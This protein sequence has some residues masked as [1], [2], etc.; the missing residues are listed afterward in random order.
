[1][2]AIG[3]S[4]FLGRASRPARRNLSMSMLE[5]SGGV[6]EEKSALS[7]FAG[8]GRSLSSS[9][10]TSAAPLRSA[11]TAAS[12]SA[13]PAEVELPTNDNDPSLLRIRHTSAHVM[14][15][16]VQ[17]VFPEAQVTIGPW[18]DNG[19]YYDFY[20]PDTVDEEGN[21]VPGRKLVDG[22]LKKIKKA[23]DKIIK[24]KLPIHRE[25]VS[26]EEAAAR[27]AAINEPFK[28]EILDSIPSDDIS[29]YHIGDEWW[30]LCAGPHVESTGDLAPKAI[31]LQNVA[32]AYWR[33]DEKR[34]MLQ[35][36][37]A[38]A[39]KDPKQLK[40]YKKLREEAKKRDHR[41]LGKKLDL[42][43]I[44]EDAGGGLVFWHPKGST[45]RRKIEDFWREAHIENGY[46]IV[47]T[48]HIA[49]IDLWKTSGHFDFYEEGMFD[50]MDVEGQEYQIRPMN[51]PFHCLMYKDDLRS[52]RDLPIRWAELGTVYRYERSGTLHGLM[53]VRGFTQD[54]A[55][56]FCLPDQLQDEIVAVLDL[57]ETILSRFGFNKYDVMLSTRP[58]K[59]VGS[60][61]IWEAATSALAGALAVKKWNY[62]INEGDGAFYG[63]KIDLK[64]KDAIGRTWQCSTVQCDFNL[65]VR[66]GLEYIT[67]DNTKAQPI[68]LHRAIFGSI[69]RFFG[70]LVEN[71]AGDFPLWLAPVQLILLPVTDSV[72]D[73]CTEV[74]KKAAKRGIRVEIDRGNERLAKQIRN[75]EQARVPLIGVVGVKE[76][77]SRKIA[78]R[79]KKLGDLGLHGIEDLLDEIERCDENAV[80]MELMGEKPPKP[81]PVA[82]E[83]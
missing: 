23:M 57:F 56:V 61:E 19:F 77:E 6:G 17:K 12:P 2:R 54:D 58:E 5:R 75:A 76:L 11:A 50:Q 79:S 4:A 1:M 83:K 31:A 72:Q 64:I 10:V 78:L 22:D 29:I 53:R 20:F 52:Y 41:L 34:E 7:K 67:A 39:W 45:M 8:H 43:S 13:P 60:D 38:T 32:G 33:G 25:D 66:F 24:A 62:Q 42:F 16:A 63:P 47:F 81:E 35:R 70:I 80:E 49:N 82:E 51:C 15:M 36:I 26:R 73:Y 30:D 3:C 71:C 69:E 14:A 74:K 65:P 44:Q 37:Y 9:R 46:D 21:A 48:P 68:M 55:H 59:S 18:I 28:K 27:I 40:A